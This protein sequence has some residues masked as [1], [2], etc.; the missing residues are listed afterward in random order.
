MS[1]INVLT[2]LED[3]TFFN[4]CYLEFISKKHFNLLVYDAD[5]SYDSAS[6]IIAT[7]CLNKHQWFSQLNGFKILIDNTWEI[8]QPSDLVDSHC[9]FSQNFFWYNESLH[10]QH[11]GLDKYTPNKTYNK[12][13][14]VPMRLKKK[15]RDQLFQKLPLDK[16][17]YSYNG[18]G[19]CLPDDDNNDNR[20]FNSQWYN[21]TYF[22]ISAETVVTGDQLFITEKTF[23]PIAFYHPFM[24]AGQP[25]VLYH[26]KQLG[27]ETYDNMFDES[28]D[29]MP[30]YSDRIT[31]IIDN[32]NSFN[33]VAY[34]KITQEKIEYNRNRFFNRQLVTEKFEQEII[35]PIIEY[36]ETK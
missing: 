18:I 29:S 22:S 4:S 26:L 8:P 16:C 33:P 20:Y 31:K 13:A 3:F 14:L 28:Y 34:D 1:K 21:D 12:L 27:F 19:H 15:S 32:L 2:H 10:Y 5:V 25:G 30:D 9:C 11:L 17:I 7:N 36:F 35:Q 24:V 23:K 6:T